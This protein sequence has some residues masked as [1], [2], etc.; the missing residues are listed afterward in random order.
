MGMER[1][2]I[3]GDKGD[4]SVWINTCPIASTWTGLELKSGLHGERL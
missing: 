1:R 2:W 3:G 4:W